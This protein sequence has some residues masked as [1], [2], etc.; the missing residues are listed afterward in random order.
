MKK[1]EN[2]AEYQGQVAPADADFPFGS[3][4]DDPTPGLG[5]PFVSLT[6]NEWQ[7]MLQKGF[8]EA[9]I[10]PN[11]S[12]DTVAS[13]QIYD[14]FQAVFNNHEKASNRSAANS[15]PASAIQINNGFD[16][17]Q[18]TSVTPFV[19]SDN[20]DT[21][22][23]PVGRIKN[24]IGANQD[25]YVM[26]FGDSHGW[27]QGAPE[28][29]DFTD[30]IN[31]S[32][33][34]A[35]IYNKGFMAR[36]ENW[37]NSGLGFN[38]G[39]YGGGTDQL[40]TFVTD[41]QVARRHNGD[42][43]NAKPIHIEGGNITVSEENYLGGLRA[44]PEFYTPRCR[45]DVDTYS[46]DVYREKLSKGL[47]DKGVT[48]LEK[49]TVDTFNPE[50]KRRF[51]ELRPDTTTVPYGGA[52]ADIEWGNGVAAPIILGTKDPSTQRVYL[53]IAKPQL[54]WVAEDVECF[55]PGYG[56]AKFG[57]EIVINGNPSIQIADQNGN[58]AGDALARVIAPNTRIYPKSA[59]VGLMT[60]DM[61]AP[62]RVMYISVISQ[63]GG[64]KMRV[65]FTPNR[66]SGFSPLHETD[67][68]AEIS[69]VANDWV[70][71]FPGDLNKPLLVNSNGALTTS[72]YIS[73]DALGFVID[74]DNTP[75]GGAREEYLFRVD[76]GGRMQGRVNLTLGEVG[77]DFVEFRGVVFDNNKVANY[78]M[79]GHTVG[80]WLGDE[81]SFNDPARDHVADILNYTPVQP[82]HVITQIPFVNEYLKQT[83]I[84]T[85]KTRLQNFVDRFE[86]HLVPATSTNYNLVGVDFMFFTSLRNKEIAFEGGASDPI[87]YDMYVQATKEFCQDNGHAFVDCEQHLFDMVDNGRINYERLFQNSN[88]PSDYANEL[89]FK[90]LKSEYL[91]AMI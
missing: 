7:A 30:F 56:Y 14:M 43:E 78:S 15:H 89:I 63:A 45:D 61:E 77:S 8:V 31:F 5:T 34:S 68:G 29:D 67:T 48:R 24:V 9:G 4:I 66:A 52:F 69:N 27:G 88:H 75:D 11:G 64:G 84:A 54:D 65:E 41:E 33:H 10:V 3:F 57:A 44:Q 81:P 73:A 79:G 28:W 2:A 71:R 38:T 50:G 40:S 26:L 82:S 13:S 86:N 58:P 59:A 74:T 37:L 23:L 22:S 62:A 51:W 70:W 16:V 42:P 53:R 49:C 72:P 25:Q 91:H 36:I 6:E 18:Q 60:I 21:A 47:F 85:F 87:T 1:I 19:D 32:S 39:R 90:V 12:A 76:L 35:A 46:Q 20:I 17:Q 80:A 83:P 55:V